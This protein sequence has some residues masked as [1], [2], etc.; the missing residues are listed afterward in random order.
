MLR[1]QPHGQIFLCTD[2][3]VGFSA[4]HDMPSDASFAIDRAEHLFLLR[5]VGANVYIIVGKRYLWAGMK[6]NYLQENLD[7]KSMGLLRLV[8]CMSF[9]SSFSLVC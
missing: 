6:L 5:A 9:H 8:V 1:P 3:T 2:Y 4:N 7:T